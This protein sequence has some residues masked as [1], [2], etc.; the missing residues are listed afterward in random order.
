M[1]VSKRSVVITLG[2]AIVATASSWWVVDLSM[3]Y[4]G[5]N[6]LAD[7]FVLGKAH[8]MTYQKRQINQIDA[9]HGQADQ[10]WLYADGHQ[11]YDDVTMRLYN[12]Q[13]PDQPPWQIQAPKAKVNSDHTDVWL[14][15]HVVATREAFGSQPP[16]TIKTKQ[17]HYQPNEQTITTDQWVTIQQT[18]T[19][20]GTIGKGLD[21]QINQGNY[22][23]LSNVRS[24]DA[25]EQSN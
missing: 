15:N 25:T 22:Q 4:V 19:A 7:D 3:Q 14:H 10:A 1:W 6:D 16:M 2:L 17:A 21:G 9:Y 20:N 23:L 24:Y 12:Q 13:K 18:D 11:S 5:Q 8:Q